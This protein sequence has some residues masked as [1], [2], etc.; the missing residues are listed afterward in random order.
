MTAFRQAVG[1]HIGHTLRATRRGLR[2]NLYDFQRRTRHLIVLRP[3]VTAWRR[4]AL[5]QALLIATPAKTRQ[6][7]MNGWL[8]VKFE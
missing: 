3:A 8:L 2:M 1:D 7:M 4:Q 5:V 6:T